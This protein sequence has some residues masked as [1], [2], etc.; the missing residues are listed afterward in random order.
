[1]HRK[2]FVCLCRQTIRRICIIFNKVHSMSNMNKIHQ[3]EDKWRIFT[4]VR[5]RTDRQ[6]NR[7]HNHF[8]TLL[9]LCLCIIFQ[10]WLKIKCIVQLKKE[11]FKSTNET[12]KISNF[13]SSNWQRGN[14]LR[15]NPSWMVQN[16]QKHWISKRIIDRSITITQQ[17]F[18]SSNT[19]RIRI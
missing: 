11:I 9:E 13:C 3:F 4:R 7:T 2:T 6:I 16:I 12:V 18:I 19:Y 17:S 14:N 15:Y 8:S 1:M 5:A 10:R